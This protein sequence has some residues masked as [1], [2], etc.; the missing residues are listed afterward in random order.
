M[1]FIFIQNETVFG[2]ATFI[3]K[4]IGVLKCTGQLRDF[5]AS[6]FPFHF[7][8][9]YFFLIFEMINKDGDHT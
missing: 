7:F 5:H 3:P 4:K 9:R 8:L 6:N 2:T 1:K